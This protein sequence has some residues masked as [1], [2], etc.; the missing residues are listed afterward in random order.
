MEHVVIVYLVW[1][2]LGVMGLIGLL[3]YAHLELKK[4]GYR[5]LIHFLKDSNG[6]KRT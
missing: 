5:G 3:V 1:L 4:M 6:N 2:C